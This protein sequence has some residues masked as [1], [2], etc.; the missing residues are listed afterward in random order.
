MERSILDHPASKPQSLLQ[1]AMFMLP[2]DIGLF[3]RSARTDATIARER[4][5]RGD[6]AAF[7]AVYGEAGG[8]P[9]LSGDARFRYQRRKYDVL[10]ELLPKRRFGHVLDLGSGLGLFGRR[11]AERSESVLGVDISSQAVARARVL[12][13]G[14]GNMQFEQGDVRALSQAWTGRFDLILLA[15]TLYYLPPPLTDA[16]LKATAL[17]VAAMLA[18]GGICLLANHFFFAAD[19]DSR[20]SRRVHR[21]FAWSPGFD[22]IS[23]HRRPFYL[24]SLLAGVTA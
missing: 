3:I 10:T 12:H 4:A 16:T 17:G 13:A 1:A 2:R 9:W 8:D 23:E 11:V 5:L 15:D 7:D 20:L 6:A 18:P 24:A 21:A 22:V 19:P 14:Q